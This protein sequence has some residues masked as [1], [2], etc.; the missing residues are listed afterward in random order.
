[1]SGKTALAL[2]LLLLAPAGASAEAW[3]GSGADPEPPGPALEAWIWSGADPHRTAPALEAAGVSWYEY[4]QLEMVAFEA[5]PLTARLLV[6]AHGG[7]ITPAETYRL[8]L[9][10]SVPLIEADRVRDAVGVQRNGPTVLVV[11]TGVD[12]THPDFQDSLVANLA[13]ERVGGLIAGTFA[14]DV[15][16]DE[17]GHGTHVAGIVGGT[18]EGAG[19]LDETSGKYVG[20]YGNGRIAGFQASTL[21]EEPQV[22]S[23]AAL[24]AFD[25]ALE[26]QAAY[27][28]RVVVNSW[29]LPGDL[30]PSH[31]INE[32]TQRL[33]FNGINVI[34]S[35]G[36]LG[37]E[38]RTHQ[39]NKFC[40]A[41]W[42][43]CVAAGG[44][45]RNLV[46]ISSRGDEANGPYAH[47]D[48]TAPGW[49]I[50]ATNSLADL[51]LLDRSL[52]VMAGTPGENLYI[53]RGGTSMAAPHVGGTA[54]LLYAANPSL[55]P[56]Q[57]MDILV[58][59]TAPMPE[60]VWDA[61][62][63]YLNA[64]EAYNLAVQTEGNRQAFLSGNVVKYG[65]TAT[66]DPAY[67]DD[68]VTVGYTGTPMGGARLLEAPGDQ[69]VG[70]SSIPFWILVGLGVVGVLAGTRPRR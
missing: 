46:A 57:V 36:N 5:D 37:T 44:A 40:Q 66:G 20:V 60:T 4:E 41:P 56:D 54:A 12:S 63:G 3:A 8:H 11:D 45:D 23:L 22:D 9:D 58:E 25:W 35:A 7:H 49:R 39:L 27:D 30:D 68:P 53:E 1:M 15:V 48:L 2:L 13:A 52:R 19:P 42:V 28:V 14:P 6:A 16:V 47:P 38:G 59:T 50:T 55:S 64:R 10:R 29:G 26:N 61:G 24:E 18:G 62:T 33:Y 69:W 70:T 17:S 67:A 21:D 31:P 65:G 34:F 32:A 51:D 43:L